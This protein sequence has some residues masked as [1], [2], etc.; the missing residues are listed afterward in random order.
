MEDIVETE[1]EA[2]IEG[3]HYLAG[4]TLALSIPSVCSKFALEKDKNQHCVSCN[5]PRIQNC[6]T[7]DCDESD[8]YP[9]WYNK[10]VMFDQ[11]NGVECYALRCEILHNG[12]YQLNNQSIIENKQKQSKNCKYKLFIPF[13]GDEYET[14][15]ID[16]NGAPKRIS[17]CAGAL[18]RNI[19]YGYIQFKSMYPD[20][21]FPISYK[22]DTSV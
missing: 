12:D 1:L 4:L 9:K 18:I 20:F 5:K 13:S 14:D 16:D 17:F 11:L 6:Y 21:K 19:L 10:Y 8:R 15:I 7:K 3:H 22:N 2:M